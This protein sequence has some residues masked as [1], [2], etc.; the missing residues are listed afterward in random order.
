MVTIPP[1]EELDYYTRRE[2]KNEQ[3]QK[4]GFIR[5]W[6]RKGKK[7]FHIE[8]KCPF[9]GK[10]QERDEVFEKKPYRPVCESCGKS[11]TVEKMTKK[12]IKAKE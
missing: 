5:M 7:E 3:G 11:V 9:C 8:M 6:R 2:L 10:A 1:L 4:T 12:K